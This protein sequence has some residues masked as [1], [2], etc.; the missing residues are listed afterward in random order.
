MT[1]RHDL[2]R[3]DH[4]L[5]E[6][7]ARAERATPEQSAAIQREHEGMDPKWIEELRPII[8]LLKPFMTP[9]ERAAKLPAP[10]AAAAADREAASATTLTQH[11]QALQAL[12]ARCRERLPEI[13]STADRVSTELHQI[14]DP[15]DTVAPEQIERV[16]QILRS[17][18]ARL[19]LKVADLVLADLYPQFAQEDRKKLRESSLADLQKGGKSEGRDGTDDRQGKQ[20]LLPKE[21]LRRLLEGETLKGPPAY[22]ELIDA[23]FRGLSQERPD[24][25]TQ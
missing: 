12:L 3:L 24:E 18:E 5:A 20:H 9:E 21:I 19:L 25:M 14:L 16:K 7:V 23:Y 10:W 8:A 22:Q 2:D 11:Q 17:D 6:L 15:W 13:L 1:R 4:Q